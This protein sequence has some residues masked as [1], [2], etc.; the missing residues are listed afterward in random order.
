MRWVRDLGSGRHENT[1]ERSPVKQKAP[2]CQYRG[3]FVDLGREDRPAL[4]GQAQSP[5][6]VLHG[7]TC[8]ILR[9]I[10]AH[11]TSGP[12]AQRTNRHHL[13]LSV[14]RSSRVTPTR[15]PKNCPNRYL[16]VMSPI[17]KLLFLKLSV[18]QQRVIEYTALPSA[19]CNEHA[20]V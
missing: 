16:R 3:F 2:I 13:H 12:A 15:L 18:G 10:R 1:I 17:Q 8:I 20:E 14:R 7:A 9:L 5:T 19:H 6:C 11:P 4:G